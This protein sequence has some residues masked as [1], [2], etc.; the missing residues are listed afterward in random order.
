MRH[1]VGVS[2]PGMP[3]HTPG[4]SLA[5]TKGS[6]V[7]EDLDLEGPDVVGPSFACLP[8]MPRGCPISMPDMSCLDIFGSSYILRGDSQVERY[9]Q[10]VLMRVYVA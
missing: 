6:L 2:L 9:R 1:T 7:L 8:P 3:Q 10:C 4:V 5:A